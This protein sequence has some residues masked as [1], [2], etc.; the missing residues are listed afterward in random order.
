MLPPRFPLRP[1]WGGVLHRDHETTRIILKI[2]LGNLFMF[3][4]PAQQ[5]PSTGADWRKLVEK[6]C[7]SLEVGGFRPSGELTASCFGEIRACLSGEKWPE[8]DDKPLWPVCQLNL[9]NAPYVPEC[10]GDI[11]MLQV[12][13][14]P[15][16]GSSD[17]TIINSQ[18]NP[19]KSSFFIR[20]YKTL[21]GLEKASIPEHNSTFKAF[22]ARWNNDVQLDY[23]THDTMPI[24]FDA[25]GIGDY[26][27]QENIEQ[28]HATKL[29]GW[30]SCIQSEPW[31][32]YR[33]EGQG[34]QYALQIDSEPKAH[35]TWGDSGAVFIARHSTTK[36]L[37]AIDIQYY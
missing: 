34:F 11:A 17:F 33:K 30:P 9:M 2:H 26:Y 4:P 13:A 22:E 15:E 10:L 20:F 5:K 37:W 3:D 12:F 21:D 29:G 36:H 16:Y 14:S 6:P 28:I 25:L 32:D 19:P 18:E 23:P 1:L 8:H 7:S 35:C 27:D 24:D 31:W